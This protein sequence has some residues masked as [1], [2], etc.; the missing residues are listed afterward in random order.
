M[1]TDDPMP[2]ATD[3][4]IRAEAE[5]MAARR[6]EARRL[7]AP[8]RP[9]EAPGRPRFSQPVRQVVMML[10]VLALV[11]IGAA[12]AYGRIRDVFATSPWLNGA[13]GAVFVLGV[14]TCFWQVGQ[15]VR[16][17]SWIERFAAGRAGD[18][19]TAPLL[20]APLAAL[21]GGRHAG[22][23][24]SD[25][26]ARGMQDSVAARIEEARDITRYLA[27]LLIFLGLLG[28]FYGLATTVPAVVDTIR[29]LAPQPG[30]SAVDLFEKLMT[31]LEGQLGG[32][33]TAFS[34][35]LLGLAGSLVVGLLELF[36]THGQNRFYRELEEWMTSFT[37]LAPAEGA[38]AGDA[39]LAE[40]TERLAAQMQALTA[41]YAERDQLAELDQQAADER[42]LLMARTV[43]TMAQDA[44]EAADARAREGEAMHTLLSELVAVMR[45]AD[46]APLAHAQERLIELTEAGLAA[47]RS[48]AE[49]QARLAALTEAT[50]P[51]LDRIAA[52]QAQLLA[53]TQ[54][55]A[56]RPAPD[57]ENLRALAEATPAQLDRL[58]AGQAQLA[59][60]LRALAERPGPDTL[61]TL[62]ARLSDGQE[63]LI[64]LAE[65]SAEDRA[66]INTEAA[67]ALDEMRAR[68][69]S[70][71]QQLARLAEANAE[72]RLTMQAELRADLATLTRAVRRLGGHAHPDPAGDI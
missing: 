61:Q 11:G 2:D 26:A 36:V 70:L 20:L 17:V 72:D 5:A 32:M 71:D 35:S 24:I 55:L 3:P 28:T 52:D 62:A 64:A 9:V 22:G 69:R 60:A 1:S 15:L 43:E 21:L 48:S 51:L 8:A 16:S 14:L 12:L 41:F 40:F 65:I 10:V 31:G 50:P 57:P 33:A 54:A 49:A 44:R 42:A 30:E 58:A 23:A 38:A 4:E 19:D 59:A 56:T 6:A 18:A 29:S 25:A 39:P 47:N 53:T 37:R 68:L 46:T 7:I 27:N 34:S 63:R 13:I 67:A 66:A 45:T